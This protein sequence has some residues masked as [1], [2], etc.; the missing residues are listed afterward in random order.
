MD[1]VIDVLLDGMEKT[2]RHAHQT[3]DLL[4]IVTDA[5]V[6]GMDKTAVNVQTTLDRA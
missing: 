1:N 5:F 4:V 2:V 3:L 6:V